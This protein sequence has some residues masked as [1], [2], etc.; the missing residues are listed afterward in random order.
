MVIEVLVLET[1]QVDDSTSTLENICRN[2]KL[3]SEHSERKQ[4]PVASDATLANS[5]VIICNSLNF[6]L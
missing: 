2:E 5:L 4:S 3:V 1:D 6:E